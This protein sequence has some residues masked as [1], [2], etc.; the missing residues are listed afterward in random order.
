MSIEATL[1]HGTVVHKRF[2]PVRHRL[3]Y[4]VFNV[5][6]PLEQIDDICSRIWCLSRNRF[7]L[8]SFHDRD[9]GCRDGLNVAEYVENTFLDAG[10]SREFHSYYALL[11]PRILG[12]AF[13]PLTTYF[14]IDRTGEIAA[15]LY[16]V[17][18]TFGE[19]THYMVAGGQ[20]ENGV[21]TQTCRKA[22]HVSPFNEADGDYGFRVT[23][24]DDHISVGVT[25]RRAREPV[26]NAYFSGRGTP[27]TSAALLKAVIRQPLMTWKVI[28]GI[29]FEAGRL[30]LKGLK[31]KRKPAF[32][33]LK[34]HR[35]ER[36]NS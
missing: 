24:P 26:L 22:F 17:S 9:H 6:L 31:L 11:Y 34:V 33:G 4:S 28:I 7:N 12:Y 16:E 14:A 25:L 23:L 21:L 32:D 27:L 10:F 18:N 19:H 35:T 30:W 2:K 5:L 13:N 20:T 1:Y 3:S 8:V 15:M 29:H 36:R